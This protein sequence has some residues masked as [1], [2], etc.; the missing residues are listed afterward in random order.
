[1]KVL[2]ALLI[3][4]VVLVAVLLGFAG[5]NHYDVQARGNGPNYNPDIPILR[6]PDARFEALTRF[7]RSSR[8]YVEINDPELGALRVHYLDEGPKDGHVI[9][10]LH[11]PGR[12]GVIPTET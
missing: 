2:R 9:L 3:I 7:F 10:L 8:H 12:R 6:T 4:I 1:M 5:Y 11:R